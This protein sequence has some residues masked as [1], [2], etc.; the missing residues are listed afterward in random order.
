M[1][2][3]QNSEVNEKLILAQAWVQSPVLVNTVVN[4]GVSLKEST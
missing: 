1:A 2:D 3:V 4:L